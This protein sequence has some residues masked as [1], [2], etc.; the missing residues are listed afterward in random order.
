M[1][2]FPALQPLPEHMGVIQRLREK[3]DEKQLTGFKER[4][5]HTCVTSVMGLL[6]SR[7]HNQ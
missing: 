3:P 4:R 6:C 2:L 7:R 1:L 5:T